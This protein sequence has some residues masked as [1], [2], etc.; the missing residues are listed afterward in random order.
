MTKHFKDASLGRT[1][2]PPSRR[3]RL[4]DYFPFQNLGLNICAWNTPLCGLIYSLNTRLL[5]KTSM[6]LKT[7][8]DIYCFWNLKKELH[9]LLHWRSYVVQADWIFKEL[10]QLIVVDGTQGCI[11]NIHDA[12]A[13]A[14]WIFGGFLSFLHMFGSRRFWSFW[15]SECDWSPDSEPYACPWH[16]L[17]FFLQ[18]AKLKQICPQ[19]S[20]ANK[21]QSRKKK[22][23]IELSLLAFMTFA[24]TWCAKFSFFFLVLLEKYKCNVLIT[25]LEAIKKVV[26]N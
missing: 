11:V 12:W 4:D 16:A 9:V 1:F 5:N 2:G 6:F 14:A 23:E 17:A 3:F 26:I 24:T 20:P 22:R 10:K 13:F 25:I 8:A 7:S 19:Y 18:R 21:N 15:T